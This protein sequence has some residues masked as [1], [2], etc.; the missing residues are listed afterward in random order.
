MF[1]LSINFTLV[2]VLLNFFSVTVSE[3]DSTMSSKNSP[4]NFSWF[5]GQTISEY[6]SLPTK[7][8]TNFALAPKE[9]SNQKNKGTFLY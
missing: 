7:Q 9:W 3:S 4:W 1:S 6:F 8:L 2:V 5:K